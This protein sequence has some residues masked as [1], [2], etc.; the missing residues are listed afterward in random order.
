MADGVDYRPAFAVFSEIFHQAPHI[1]SILYGGSSPN[2]QVFVLLDGISRILDFSKVFC[3]FLKLL[4]KNK[5]L[6]LF[7]E[8]YHHYVLM[9]KQ[10]HNIR[11]VNITTA[12]GLLKKQKDEIEKFCANLYGTEKSIDFN[13]IQAPEI[14]GGTM[15]E[16][17]GELRDASLK[18]QIKQLTTHIKEADYAA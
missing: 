3:N 8:I 4:Y 12:T 15:I 5:R 16:S 17:D 6:N 11:T 9:Y 1:R 18:T 13:Y 10:S 14:L 7:E 2:G